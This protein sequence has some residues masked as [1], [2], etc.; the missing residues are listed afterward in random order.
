MACQ[1]SLHFG[2]MQHVQGLAADRATLRSTAQL[3]K[4]QIKN[5][6]AS[7]LTSVVASA[8]APSRHS[9][10]THSLQ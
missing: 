10:V 3:I 1:R 4:T 9:V 8:F 2:M 7:K 5:V 6:H